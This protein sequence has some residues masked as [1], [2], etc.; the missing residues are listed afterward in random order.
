MFVGCLTAAAGQLVQVQVQRPRLTTRSPRTCDRASMHGRI[1]FTCSYACN[2]IYLCAY[3]VCAYFVCMDSNQEGD[4]QDNTIYMRSIE[5]G[6]IH[7]IH[8]TRDTC[9][10]RILSARART[11]L[12]RL[13][14]N[15]SY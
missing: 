3:A 9:M 11:R 5:K 8:A 2:D 4:L 10:L 7:V 12:R 6:A 14:P 1:V 15:R 13:P